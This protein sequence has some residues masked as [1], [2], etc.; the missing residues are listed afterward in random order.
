MRGGSHQTG[1]VTPFDCKQSSPFQI[2]FSERGEELKFVL[3][4]TTLYTL[5]NNYLVVTFILIL[6]R[7]GYF[8]FLLPCM[9][10][11][12]NLSSAFLT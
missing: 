7:C 9:H 10:V 6:I 4:T 11:N 2:P 1:N 12:N 3:N 5:L 8:H